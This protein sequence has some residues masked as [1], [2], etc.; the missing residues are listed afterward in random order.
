MGRLH[1][2]VHMCMHMHTYIG[3][4]MVEAEGGLGGSVRYGGWH[5]STC[6]CTC[7]CTYTYIYIYIH[8]YACSGKVRFCIGKSEGRVLG[9]HVY[10]YTV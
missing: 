2:F 4:H 5:I 8:I 9:I 7:L 1:L 3:M 6:L 10:A